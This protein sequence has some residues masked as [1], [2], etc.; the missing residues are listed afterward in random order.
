[1]RGVTEQSFR[2]LGNAIPVPLSH[3]LLSLVAS[4]IGAAS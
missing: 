2:T 3:G 4:S 1:M